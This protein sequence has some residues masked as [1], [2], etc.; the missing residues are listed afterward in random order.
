MTS[1]SFSTKARKWMQSLSSKSLLDAENEGLLEVAQNP[2]SSSAWELL[3]HVYATQQKFSD[4]ADAFERACRLAPFL[5]EHSRVLWANAAFR[6]D[7]QSG[8]SL[9]EQAFQFAST[10]EELFNVS[11]EADRQGLLDIANRAIARAIERAPKQSVYLLQA[12]RV[13]QSLGRSKTA[14]R[15][16]RQVI[17]TPK[18]SMELVA[19]AW[20]GLL[21]LKTERIEPNELEKLTK[22]FETCQSASQKSLLGF[23]LGKAL[24]DVQNYDQA[25]E[26]LYVANSAAAL[27]NPWQAIKFAE[28]IQSDIGGFSSAAKAHHNRGSELIFV[29]GLPRSGTTLI[30]QILASHSKV[31][32]A[33][34]LPFLPNII[35]QESLRLGKAYEDWAPLASDA[36][37][38]R[39]AQQYLQQTARYRRQ[40]SISTD[41]L[42]ENWHYVG[43]MLRM[44]PAASVVD[45][46]R[47][48]LETIW[49]CYKQLFA[50]GRVAF[51]YRL[52]D[53]INYWRVHERAMSEWQ[54]KSPRIHRQNFESLVRA[55]D[56]EI[57]NLLSAVNLDF[58][59]SCL[60]PHLAKRA[61]NTPSS[62]Q[63][64]LPIFIGKPLAQ[65][66]P[67]LKT[68]FS[69][70][71]K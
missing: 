46:M 57:S 1:D 20:F 42:P 7:A 6:M 18:L 60:T 26:V 25:F 48:P 51:S 43:A 35:R 30:E 37:W 55:P 58:E 53:L 22:A 41:K 29:V 66:Y 36:D 5:V 9:I 54:R 11:V 33:G 23:A 68:I 31:E 2:Q 59:T 27:T 69:E 14:A 32:A 19:R 63:V 56:V 16:Y 28:R 44:F 45:C 70:N 15:L 67:M 40:K 47:D 21:D 50:P 61:V 17:D 38:D 10:P 71:S 8:E 65:Q 49:S 52:D 64:R 13:E 62:S 4:A 12:A 34:E 3:G 39:L 24:E